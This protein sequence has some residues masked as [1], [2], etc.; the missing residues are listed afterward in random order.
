M[1]LHVGQ[2]TTVGSVTVF[3]VWHDRASAGVRRYD[4]DPAALAVTEAAGG[5]SVPQLSVTNTGQRPLLIFDGQLFEGGWQHRMATRS[6]LVPAGA[7]LAIEVACVEQQRWGGGL[8]QTTRGRRASTYV[9]GGF[10]HGGGQHEVWRRVERYAG[11]SKTRSL[12]AG[13]DAV[14]G[15]ARLLRRHIRPL[16][17]QVGVLIGIAGQPLTLEV[18]DHPQ[19]LREQL[20]AILGAAA[21]DGFGQ[22]SLPTPGRR[23]RRLIERLEHTKLDWEPSVGQSAALGRATDRDLDVMSLRQSFHPLHL[24][25]AYRRNPTLQEV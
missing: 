24:R 22:A 11:S 3:P 8:N 19:T 10:D 25:A 2:G 4:T 17:G 21:L 18:F 9:R 7:Q 12:T 14:D 13:L 6:V 16:A 20:R 1:K 5:P 23:A 15:Q